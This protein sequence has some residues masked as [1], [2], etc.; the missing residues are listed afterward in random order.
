[1]CINPAGALGEKTAPYSAAAGADVPTA[2]TGQRGGRCAH[3][4]QERG[5]VVSLAGEVA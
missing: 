5:R 3:A 4:V 2:V 1:M